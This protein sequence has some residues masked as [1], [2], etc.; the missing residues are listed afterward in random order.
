MGAALLCLCAM[1]V[2]ACA[3]TSACDGRT[4]ATKP[5][6]KDDAVD[7]GD[8][9]CSRGCGGCALI[10]LWLWT[11]PVFVA[12]CMWQAVLPDLRWEPLTGLV[13]LDG[14]LGLEAGDDWPFE[15]AKLHCPAQ[16]LSCLLDGDCRRLVYRLATTDPC[17]GGHAATLNA[18][19]GTSCSSAAGAFAACL[20]AD[21]KRC[22]YARGGKP[23]VVRREALSEAEMA[24]LFDVSE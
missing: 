13:A 8:V 20:G 16:S 5:R 14:G 18:V 9:L 12:R 7:C 17:P 22:I 21:G 15:C 1:V 24:S 6:R 4:G 3:S 19:C 10:A 11:C 23:A 2:C